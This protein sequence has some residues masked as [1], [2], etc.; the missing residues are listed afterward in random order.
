[1]WKL[2]CF[3]S[4]SIL[5][6]ARKNRNWAPDQQWLLSPS[7]RDWVNDN[8]WFT[9]LAV[10]GETDLSTFA[11]PYK[12]SITGQPSVS[13]ADDGVVAALWLWQRRVSSRKIQSRCREEVAFRVIVGED[14]PDFR[15]ISDFRKDNFEHMLS[16]FVC[17]AAELMKRGR[18]GSGRCEGKDQHIA[19]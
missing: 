13:F 19:V 18:V 12:N 1:L 16:L 9:F 5:G 6:R 8:L 14:I 4:E 3:R 10:V 11:E 7:T 2:F 17:A 15:N